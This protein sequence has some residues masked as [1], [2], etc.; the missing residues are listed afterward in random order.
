MVEPAGCRY[1]RHR[2][3]PAWNPGAPATFSPDMSDPSAPTPW[4]RSRN[5][6]WP[7][8]LALLPLAVFSQAA[9]LRGVFY[10]HD[11]QFYFYPYHALA[12]SLLGRGELPLWNPFAFC[13]LPL[14][15]DGQTALFYPPNS[16]FLLLPGGAALNYDVLAQFCIAG[17]AMYAFS[18]SVALRRLPALLGAVAYMFCGFLTARVVHLSILSGAALVPLAFLCVE[19]MF[20]AWEDPASGPLASTRVRR[21]WF[22]IAA[23]AVAL[24]ALAG[25][26]QV[27]VYTALALGLYALFRG[28]E[29]SR[30]T[31]DRRLLYLMPMLLVGTYLLGYAMAAIQLA[32]WVELGRASMRSNDASFD[33]IFDN[34]MSRSDWLL[35]L[36]PYL[37][38]A[39][40]AGAYADQPMVMPLASKAWEHSAYVGMLPLGLAAYA[41]LG[42]RRQTAGAVSGR[43]AGDAPRFFALLLASGIVLAMGNAT[44]L[45]HLIV[46]APVIGKLREVARAL[47]LVDFAVA[48]LAAFGLQRVI[49]RRAPAAAGRSLVSIAVIMVSVPGTVVLLAQQPWCQRILHLTPQMAA[50]LQLP[51]MNAVMPLAFAIA[52]AALVVWWSR[53]PATRVTQAIAAGLVLLDVGSFAATFNPTTSPQLYDRRPDVLEA[54]RGATAPFRKATFLPGNDLD[55]RV[56]QETLAVSWGLVYGVEDVNGFNSLQPRRYTDYLFGPDA[57]DVSYGLLRDER[58]LRPESPILSALNVRF[59]LVPAAMQPAL[60]SNFRPVFENRQV[61][62]YEN[63][64]V[65]PRAFFAETVR[66]MN[67]PS[68]VLNAVRADG[69]DGRRLALVEADHLPAF[70]AEATQDRVTL[71]A[72]G[73]T[74]MSLATSTSATRFLVL[75]EM[76]ASGWRALVDDVETPIYR[77]NYLFRGV[78]APPGEHTVTFVYRPFS[79]RLGA[80]ISA[81]ALVAA[82]ALLLSRP[83]R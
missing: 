4:A 10:V 48:M 66:P 43:Q 67:N 28:V 16:L 82:A 62:V 13:G 83:R 51:R 6:S 8:V 64:L 63:T 57:R 77:T 37:Y 33:F 54:F 15:G 42:L 24:Q 23:A 59:L 21:R 55:N 41:L 32:P 5:W 44:P 70:P 74:R 31:G 80:G 34:S 68:E 25:H 78:V 61:R 46:R 1:D 12:A 36:F 52:S 29:R 22:V 81:L 39:L 20:R 75:S 11:V 71:T 27:P 35:Q 60:G 18:R 3:T 19:R 40:Q 2:V 58:L 9:L 38:G 65:Y 14:L 30:L 53:H 73:P 47:V 17:V 56:A 45:A 69:F 50:N 49:G 7:A 72:W 26:P 79:V 76:Q